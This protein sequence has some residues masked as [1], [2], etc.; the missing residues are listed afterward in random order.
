MS[1]VA[2]VVLQL[3]VSL[4]AAAAAFARA[5]N[6]ESR[7][8][9]RTWAIL[10]TVPM[11]VL[12]AALA[13][14]ALALRFGPS[15]VTTPWVA[16]VALLLGHVFGLV[17]LRR[18]AGARAVLPLASAFVVGGAV[19]L[20]FVWNLELRGRLLA[21]ELAREAGRIAFRENPGRVPP[22]ENAAPAYE[23]IAARLAPDAGLSVAEWADALGANGTLDPREPR[24]VAALDGWAATL[25]EAR[26]ASELPHCRGVHE[27]EL[28]IVPAPRVLALFDVARGLALEARV[29]GA[30]GDAAGALADV[31]ATFAVARH[32]LETPL[33]ISVAAAASVR[34]LAVDALVH[35]LVEGGAS[36]EELHAF[37]FDSTPLAEETALRALRLEEAFGLSAFGAFASG[38]TPF[39]PLDGAFV[40]AGRVLYVA[41][42]FEDD[43]RGYR[44]TFRAM[45]EAA[46]LP[47]GELV[48]AGGAQ[49][50]RERGVL[51][52]LL[53][54]N[55]MDNLVH[56][57][58]SDARLELA[59]LAL[60][61]ARVRARDGAY[62]T[63]AEAL[64]VPAAS[65]ALE[66]DGTYVRIYATGAHW[67]EPVEVTLTP[68]RGR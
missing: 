50:A 12:N 39:G 10:G 27:E 7:W 33:L 19:E 3:V 26:A 65:V 9:R 59:G 34:A 16:G 60:E 62:P 44:A 40:R 55:L 45:R 21:A 57:H 38:G 46:A 15:E 35:V 53:V 52:Q 13:A 61:A 56:F 54:P 25:A 1:I 48:A 51:T 43:V 11:L 63:S 8:A 42:L 24:L 68:G 64:G 22:E 18:G 67:G 36:A 6:A 31:R 4:F 30:S 47:T 29:R 5:A 23:G 32:L 20:L 41:F 58:R 49:P 2:F 14:G 37:A 66:G 17:V 28:E